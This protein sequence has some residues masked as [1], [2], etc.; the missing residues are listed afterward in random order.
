MP[1]SSANTYTSFQRTAIIVSCMLGFALDLY[2]VLIMPY[3]MPSIQHSLSI[4]LT[5]VASITSCT[6]FGSVLGGALFGWLGD[7]MGRKASLQFTLGLF[8][9]G[10]VAS[11]F[12]WDYWSLAVLRFVVGIGLGGEWGAGMV[13]FNETWNP[14]RRGLG[15][16]LIQGSAVVA[17]SCASIIGIW[18]IS[19]F[20]Q[21]MGWRVGL[22]TGGAPLILMIFIRFWMPESNAWIEFDRKRRSG[23]IPAAVRTGNPLAVLFRGRLAWIT[24]VSLVW[25]IG[26]MFCYYSIIVFMPTLMLKVLATPPEAVQVTMVAA[27]VVGGVSYIVMGWCND[28]FGRR[29]GAVV[30]CLAWLGSL[31]VLY[32]ANDTHYAGS[33][34]SWP[35]LWVAVLFAVGNSALGVVGAWLSELYPIN[36]RA[37]AVSTI[38]MAGRAA[39]SL[40][41]VIVPIAASGMGGRLADGMLIALPAAVLFLIASLVLPETRGRSLDADAADADLVDHGGAMGGTQDAHT[42]ADRIASKSQH[43]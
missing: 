39:G 4:S 34:L 19:R 8:A 5:E 3:L 13:L 1:E 42:H 9:V 40:A 35:L 7:R 26:Y 10:S 30:P 24:T 12:A 29:F 22:L 18:A 28:R 23:E 37:T 43:A 17:S 11:A 16:A 21:E 36:V 2:D 20:G 32:A 6:L 15:S 31:G 25:L 14:R 27:S 41:P 38:Y 33:L